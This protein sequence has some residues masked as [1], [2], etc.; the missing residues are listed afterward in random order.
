MVSEA[1]V[2]RF[3]AGTAE[4]AGIDDVQAA[5]VRLFQE[6]DI[7]FVCYL[8]S[9]GRLDPGD[10]I[11]FDNFDPSF[12]ERYREQRHFEADPFLHEVCYG[13]TPRIT[14]SAAEDD[15]RMRTPRQQRI[16]DDAVEFGVRSAF[17]VPTLPHG[18]DGFGGFVLS[19]G[20]DP[21]HFASCIRSHGGEI[22]LA[23]MHAHQTVRR[24][25]RG[26][27]AVEA[28]L[29]ARERE[30]LQGLARGERI[31]RIAVRLGVADVTVEMHVK[32]ARAKLGA[33]TRDQAIARA[34]AA[35]LI[36]I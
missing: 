4:A 12:M 33:A 35:G 28:G 19:S 14:C 3:I 25:A 1:H 22:R 17:F 2:D 29:S 26:S 36:V 30:C 11:A 34:V 20:G 16:R 18:P 7:P 21:R 15:W 5:L 23:A 31:S 10:L 13:L 8:G 24:V 9:F 32:N 6:Y 27:A